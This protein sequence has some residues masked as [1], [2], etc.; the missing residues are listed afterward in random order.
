MSTV[1][2]LSE[3]EKSALVEHLKDKMK[4]CGHN[5]VFGP[6]FALGYVSGFTAALDKLGIKQAEEICAAALENEQ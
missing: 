5:E 1:I 3:E 4:K 6:I 2:S